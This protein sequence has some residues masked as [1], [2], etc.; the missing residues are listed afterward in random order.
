M[1][2]L[3][4]VS[5]TPDA[6]SFQLF[7]WA[8]TAVLDRLSRSIAPALGVPALFDW[9]TGERGRIE[10]HQTAAAEPPLWVS[11]NRQ[12][13]FLARPCRL[14]DRQVLDFCGGGELFF[15]MLHRG[16]FEAEGDCSATV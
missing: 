4:T 2:N 3:Q 1:I 6:S 10:P 12:P 13:V 14:L 9:L 11:W 15:H 8:S 5:P 7:S 16:R